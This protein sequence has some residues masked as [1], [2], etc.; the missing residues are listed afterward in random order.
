MKLWSQRYTKKR[1]KAFLKIH[2]FPIL[3]YNLKLKFQK[4]L[5]KNRG[6]LRY[7]V[8]REKTKISQITKTKIWHFSSIIICRLRDFMRANNQNQK[9]Y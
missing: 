4:L 6:N 3:W 7:H 8:N 9:N 5:S 2:I 1:K